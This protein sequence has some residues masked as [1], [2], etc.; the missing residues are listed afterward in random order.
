MARNPSLRKELAQIS[1]KSSNYKVNFNKIHMEKV[2][3]KIQAVDR[4]VKQKKQVN[5]EQDY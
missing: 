1:G 3:K 2:M 5:F 4:K